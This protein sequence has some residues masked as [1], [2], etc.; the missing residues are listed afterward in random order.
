MQQVKP[1]ASATVFIGSD[2]RIGFSDVCT[3]PTDA[4]QQLNPTATDVWIPS[5]GCALSTIFR[6]LESSID[7]FGFDVL[8]CD[9]TRVLFTMSGIR[10]S[11][12]TFE[13]IGSADLR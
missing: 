4:G 10:L 8:H 13:A 5:V 11:R 1:L 7:P 3:K 2:D 9:K 6:E 12:S